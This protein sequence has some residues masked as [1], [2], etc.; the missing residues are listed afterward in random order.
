[1]KSRN[2]GIACALAL[3]TCLAVGLDGRP[4]SSIDGER[5]TASLSENKLLYIRESFPMPVPNGEPIN[6]ELELLLK[7][8]ALEYLLAVVFIQHETDYKVRVSDNL[9][10]MLPQSFCWQ[11]QIMPDGDEEDPTYPYFYDINLKEFRTDE[12]GNTALIEIFDR[13][14]GSRSSSIVT[15]RRSEL[16]LTVGSIEAGRHYDIRPE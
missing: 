5:D 3:T 2:I 14:R 4:K 15:V 6:E 10:T 11:D 7:S 9:A 1:M 12:F 16:G 13:M 8:K